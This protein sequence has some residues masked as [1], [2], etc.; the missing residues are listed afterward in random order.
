MNLINRA[1][2]PVISHQLSVF[3]NEGSYSKSQI[4]TNEVYSALS[5]AVLSDYLGVTSL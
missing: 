1:L 4:Y 3:N 5:F 2:K